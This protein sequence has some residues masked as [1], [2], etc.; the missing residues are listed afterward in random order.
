[1]KYHFRVRYKSK[2]NQMPLHT[3]G[4]HSQTQWSMAREDG[5]DRTSAVAWEIIWQSFKT[6]FVAA[7]RVSGLLNTD[8]FLSMKHMPKTPKLFLSYNET[9][10]FNS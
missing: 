3:A 1:M 10:S 2:H 9:Q 4:L 7:A 5:L 6:A 8:F